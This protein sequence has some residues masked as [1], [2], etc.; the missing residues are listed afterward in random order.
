MR[1]A[2]DAVCFTQDRAGS[3]RAARGVLDGVRARGDVDV[4]PVGGGVH[5]ARGS[6]GQRL[7]AVEQDVAWYGRGLGVAARRAAADVVHCPT[8]RG[9]LRW[10]GLPVVVTVHD[11]AVL[12]SPEWFPRWSRAYGARAVP[13]VVRAADRVICVS[14]ATADDVAGLGVPASRLRVVPNGVDAV[15]AEDAGPAPAG[16]PYLLAVATPEPRKNLARLVAAFRLLRAQGR[17]ERLLVVGGGGWGRVSVEQRD[18]VERLGRVGDRRLRDL[19]AH[20]AC[21]VYPS[22]W[23]GYG[24][25]AAEAL[26]T[27][28]RLA[29]SDLPA[30]REVAGDAAVYCDPRSVADIARAVREALE[31]PPP[32]RRVVHDWASAAALT[33][34]VWRELAP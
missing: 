34:E 14:Q 12:R 11:L 1:V 21:T 28:C 20:A 29:C 8:F 3:A 7:A 23:E 13:R 26:A 4:L 22:L 17:A 2:F 19:Y 5:L 16:A 27:G 10:P 32:A 25:V 18:G 6:A 33:V 15:F 9:P 24:L 31:R 30:L